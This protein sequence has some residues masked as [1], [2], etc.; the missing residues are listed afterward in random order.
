M[1]FLK[2]K[3]DWLWLYVRDWPTICKDYLFFLISAHLISLKFSFDLLV[4]IC[5]PTSLIQGFINCN[6]RDLH[7]V[8][9][10][11]FLDSSGGNGAGADPAADVYFG[12]PDRFMEA[13]PPKVSN[14]AQESCVLLRR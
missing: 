2:R 7:A 14:K 9:S 8:L 1:E 5:Q 3:Q 6:A 4:I 10:F 12:Q 11:L 13:A